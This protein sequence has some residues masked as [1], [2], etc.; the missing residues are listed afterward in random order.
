MKSYKHLKFAAL[1]FI[2]SVLF[3][4]AT[5]EAAEPD[6]VQDIPQT[7]VPED[8]TPVIEQITKKNSVEQIIRKDP[9]NEETAVTYPRV[10]KIKKYESLNKEDTWFLVGGVTGERAYSVF[11]DPD[12]ILNNSGLINSWSKLEFEKQQR[13][14]DGLSYIEVQINSD[15]NCEERTYSYGD[16]KFYDGLG[17]LVESQPAFYDPQPIVDGTVSAQIADFVCGY[18]LNKPK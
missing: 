9:K 12:T 6:V 17:R 7:E 3:S 18:D 13:D 2:I 5:K 11:V 8:T 4:C 15:V 16:S 10:D 14:E 1:L